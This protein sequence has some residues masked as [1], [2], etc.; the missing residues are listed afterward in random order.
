MVVC[1]CRNVPV[2]CEKAAV[3]GFVI[4]T[5][6]CIVKSPRHLRQVPLRRCDFLVRAQSQFWQFTFI[7]PGSLCCN[8]ESFPIISLFMKLSIQLLFPF[9]WRQTRHRCS[10]RPSQRHSPRYKTSAL[11]DRIYVQKLS[12]LQL[13]SDRICLQTSAGSAQ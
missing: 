5:V 12:G 2:N 1:R 3:S 4:K 9:S 13:H 7:T 11:W 10:R 8:L 6:S